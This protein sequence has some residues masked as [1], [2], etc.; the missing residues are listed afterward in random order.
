MKED[1]YAIEVKDVDNTFWIPDER[2][3]SFKNYFIQPWKLL[4]RKG[5]RFGALND[6]SFKVKKGEFVGVIG[7]NGS[8]KSTLLKI[9]AGIYAPDRGEIRV[10]GKLIPFLELG[11]GFNPELS[12]RENIYLNGAILG[13]T[14]KFLKTKSNEI[15]EFAGVTKFADTPIKNFSSGMTVRLAFAIAIQAKA[16]IY[17]LD[18]VLAVGD[19]SFKRKS[20]K[21]IKEL[22]NSGVTVIYVS[23]DLSSVE[24][25]TDRAIWIHD[26]R[27]KMDGE[28][29][30]VVEEFQLSTLPKAERARYIETRDKLRKVKGLER[31]AAGRDVDRVL[32]IGEL[33]TDTGDGRAEIESV[34]ILDKGN[35]PIEKL[36]I[37]QHFKVEVNLKV[38][39][40]IDNP[41]LGVS[42]R[43]DINAPLF[44]LNTPV[45]QDTIISSLKPGNRLKV[46]FDTTNTLN[47]GQYHVLVFLNDP[48]KFG[49]GTDKYA[50][51]INSFSMIEVVENDA[52]K[53]REWRGIMHVP[54]EV[55]T[56][57][58]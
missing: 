58:S 50:A 51:K 3:S 52:S 55:K 54:Y 28:P 35:K 39:R 45:N 33:K 1:Q 8:G 37:D 38:H 43:K 7:K 46:V 42:L 5:H 20:M 44:D 18:E 40:R 41:V 49:R 6:I 14:R 32:E 36:F 56:V 47:I 27:V 30:S 22:I 15:L 57:I 48:K 17:L 29:L 31:I 34:R 16:D 26:S 53:M 11:V 10:N 21:K 23:H 25:L 4:G 2:F 24:A 9:L 13:M 12:A 19:D